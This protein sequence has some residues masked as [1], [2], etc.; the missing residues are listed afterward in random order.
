MNSGHPS[1][2]SQLER[3]ILY[4]LAQYTY[5]TVSQF[6]MLSLRS[7]NKKRLSAIAKRLTEN[8]YLGCIRGER[9]S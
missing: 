4:S 2:L 7:K 6:Q 9:F 1:F 8:G 3:Q 5:L